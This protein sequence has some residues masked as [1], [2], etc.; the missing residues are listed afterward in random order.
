MDAEDLAVVRARIGARRDYEV[1]RETGTLLDEDDADPP[2]VD[3]KDI[4]AKYEARHGGSGASQVQRRYS[5]EEKHLT[6]LL[7]EL[8]GFSTGTAE[9]KK[10]VDRV[11]GDVTALGGPDAYAPG[12]RMG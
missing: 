12:M 8:G 3:F 4:Q 9:A 7:L 5:N 11:R 1:S 6:V 2:P 10:I